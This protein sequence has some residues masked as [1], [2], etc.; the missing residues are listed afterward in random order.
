MRI[1]VEDVGDQAKRARRVAWPEA[2]VA[3]LGLVLEIKD[4]ESRED[5]AESS[6]IRV[7]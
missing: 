3:A 2:V 7:G 1:V 4:D 5:G 6:G